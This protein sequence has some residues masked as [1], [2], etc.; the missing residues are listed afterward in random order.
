VSEYAAWSAA[1]TAQTLTDGVTGPSATSSG[2]VFFPRLDSAAGVLIIR[3]ID[4]DHALRDGR[5]GRC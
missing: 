3:V 5:T 1:T 4:L 2:L